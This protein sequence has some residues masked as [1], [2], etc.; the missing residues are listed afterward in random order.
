MENKSP[1]QIHWEKNMGFSLLSQGTTTL[2]ALLRKTRMDQAPPSPGRFPS[3]TGWEIPRWNPLSPGRKWRESLK[4][5]WVYCNS[6]TKNWVVMII[7]QKKQQINKASW[8]GFFTNLF[9]YTKK[10]CARR[11]ASF[12]CGDR[13]EFKKYLKPAPWTSDLTPR[14]SNSKFAPFLK[15]T[16]LKGKVPSSNHQFSGVNSLLV[17]GREKSSNYTSRRLQLEVAFG[18]WSNDLPVISTRNGSRME[19]I[20]RLIFWTNGWINISWSECKMHAQKR[21]RT[22]LK[23]HWH[24]KCLHAG[25]A[26]IKY[27]CETTACEEIS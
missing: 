1:S 19:R 24:T 10:T 27:D 25:Y 8:V 7:S 9:I 2:R 12:C 22:C 20:T 5:W 3:R 13:G 15:Q 14:E 21:L 26:S 4:K 16:I 6:P 18:R 17:S 11:M 23:K